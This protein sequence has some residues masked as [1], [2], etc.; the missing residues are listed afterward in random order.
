M[1]VNLQ[2]VFA[3]LCLAGCLSGC[4]G[5][6]T[7]SVDEGYQNSE[8]GD[9]NAPKGPVGISPGAGNQEA[10]MNAPAPPPLQ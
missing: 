1:K 5:G 7:A 4:G 10:E 9:P 2:R 6:N 3:V 8:P